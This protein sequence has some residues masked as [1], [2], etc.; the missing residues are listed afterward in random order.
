MDR[1]NVAESPVSLLLGLGLS[2]EMLYSSTDE[3]LVM[4]LTLIVT[5]CTHREGLIFLKGS[6]LQKEKY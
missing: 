2:R 4:W 6:I 5:R 3:N 1:Y